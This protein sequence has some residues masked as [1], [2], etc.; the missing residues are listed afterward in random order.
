MEMKP[1]LKYC[2]VFG[3]VRSD[4]AFDELQELVKDVRAEAS[5][6]PV[7]VKGATEMRHAPLGGLDAQTLLKGAAPPALE[8]LADAVVRSTQAFVKSRL[9][10]LEAR[11]RAL[12]Q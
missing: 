8:A 10:P 6:E 5:G 4:L 1:R 12:E 3:R 2:D 7:T 11:I 9:A